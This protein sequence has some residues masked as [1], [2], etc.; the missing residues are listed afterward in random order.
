MSADQTFPDHTLF[1]EHLRQL[2]TSRDKRVALNR[3][4][5]TA[6]AALTT[7]ERAYVLL[8]SGGRCHICG[9]TINGQDWQADHVFAFSAGGPGFLENYLPAHSICNNYR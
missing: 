4:K 1:A 3:Q 5:R 9:G 2:K 6:R 7:A 8:K